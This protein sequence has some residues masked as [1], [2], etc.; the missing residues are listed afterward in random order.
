MSLGVEKGMEPIVDIRVVGVGGGGSNVVNHMM[1]L[2]AN[3]VEF[4]AVNT[5]RQALNA[6]T[7]DHKVQIGAGVTAGQGAGSD[8]EI[9]LRSAEESRVQ[10]ANEI[11]GAD[12]LFITAGMGGGTGTGAAPILATIAR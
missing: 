5:D 10:L 9:G 2:G 11:R 4:I 7:A 1:A 6:S 12:I 3:G 8:P